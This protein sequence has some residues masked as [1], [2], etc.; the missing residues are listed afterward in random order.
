MKQQFLKGKT[1]T[2]RLT[3]YDKNRPLI[4]TSALITLYKSD[5]TTVLQAQASA[6]VDS[7][8]G[9]MTYS[10]TTTHTATHD[11]NYKA[12]WQYVV[13]GTTYYETQLFDVVKSILS[14]PITDDDLYAELESL[15]KANIQ[16]QGTA[17]GGVA[18]T[19]IDTARRKEATDFWK[20]GILEILS[21]TGANQKRDITGFTQSSSTFTVSPDWATTP[22]TDS[23]YRCINS[24]STK[25][26]Q[27]FKK[28]ETMLYNKG[29]RDSLILESSQIEMPLIYLTVHFIAL[30]LMDE[31]TDKWSLI[32]K[33]YEKKFDDS[34]NTM[35]LDYD[36]DESG[37]V[38]GEEAQ[39]GIG[40]IRIFRS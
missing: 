23:V 13:S 21:G 4:P 38:Q 26:L 30:D 1:G 7:T 35:T 27:S 19:L 10:L 18:G 5:G 17:T 37:G 8:T 14:I 6:S 39:Q 31:D 36:E 29:K 2:I 9:E 34:F 3:A 40:G 33:A 24:F 15:R 22:S 12:V 20:G 25:I 32:A 11:L 28:I 16:A